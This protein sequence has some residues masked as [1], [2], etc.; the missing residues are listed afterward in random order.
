MITQEKKGKTGD[1]SKSAGI[2]KG[3]ILSSPLVLAF[4]ALAGAL[5]AFILGYFAG[6]REAQSV[7]NN[8][9]RMNTILQDERE[10]LGDLKE[11]SDAELKEYVAANTELNNRVLEIATSLDSQVAAS[12][13]AGIWVM[14]L[15]CLTIVLGFSAWLVFEFRISRQ[16]E[17]TLANFRAVIAENELLDEQGNLIEHQHESKAALPKPTEE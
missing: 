11:I 15:L 13:N 10:R 7:L 16:A 9:E 5:I 17:T 4:A 8:Y 1:Q 12:A 6:R 14:A 3:V 2:L